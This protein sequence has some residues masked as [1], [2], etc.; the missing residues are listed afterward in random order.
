MTLADH[1]ILPF[2]EHLAGILALLALAIFAI[3]PSLAISVKRL[4]D[5]N[6][7]G[8]LMLIAL[9]PVIGAIWLL[10]SLGFMKGTV[11][12]NKFGEDPFSENHA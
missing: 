8:W 10:V 6:H 2:Y 4:H 11:G 7:S 1:G 3:W 12:R 9:I 5:R